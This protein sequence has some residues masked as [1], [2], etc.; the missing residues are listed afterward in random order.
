MRSRIC[1][2]SRR[3]QMQSKAHANC[4]AIDQNAGK[5]GTLCRFERAGT[6]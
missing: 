5:T 3:K 4:L 1:H 2:A 6:A